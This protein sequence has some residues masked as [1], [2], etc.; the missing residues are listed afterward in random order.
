MFIFALLFILFI[1]IIAGNIVLYE[2]Y[3]YYPK[4]YKE[5]SNSV[6]SRQVDDLVLFTNKTIYFK[7][8]NDFKL[9]DD[10]YLHNNFVTYTSIYGWYWLIKY[11]K[12]M[13]IKFYL[14]L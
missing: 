4:I 3:K 5:L 11:Q 12:L 7:D 9:G 10:I 13:K 2:E 14:S 8:T 6:I 1:P